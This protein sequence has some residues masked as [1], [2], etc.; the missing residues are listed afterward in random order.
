M[1][2]RLDDILYPNNAEVWQCSNYNIYYIFKNGSQSIH[3]YSKETGGRVWVNEQIRKLEKIDVFLR[4]PKER[5]VSGVATNLYNTGN[6]IDSI[7]PGVFLDRHYLP[8][9]LWIL[10][11]LRFCNPNSN[12]HLH[13]WGLLKN[14]TPLRIKVDKLNTVDPLIAEHL[15]LEM[16][17]RLDTVLFEEMTGNR[18]KPQGL[19]AHLMSRDPLAY[20]KVF[21]KASKLAEVTHVLPTP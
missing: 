18:W 12:I 5:Y 11:L 6:S 20:F 7:T 8:Q 19:M 3:T 1:F 15:D 2:T 13:H 17:M 14:V 10:N 9:I 16:Y 4:E 21:G